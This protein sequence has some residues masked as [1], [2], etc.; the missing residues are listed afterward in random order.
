MRRFWLAA[1]MLGTSEV[2]LGIGQA[3]PV[4]AGTG[5]I[6]GILVSADRGEPVRKATVRLAAS[7]PRLNRSVTT[8]SDGR[9]RFEQLPAAEYTLTAVKGGFVDATYGAR[10]FGP[11]SSGA[12]IVGTPVTLSAG[13]KIEDIRFPIPRGGVI[14]GTV[15]DEFGDPAFNVVVRALRLAVVNG[16]RTVQPAGL[17]GTTDD[18]G[19]FRIAGLP[20][21]EYLVTA[22]PRDT[23]A[24][25]SSTNEAL[26]M[27]QA[28]VLAAARAS[29]D[30]ARVAEMERNFA[31]WSASVP[32]TT[33]G[34]VPVYYPGVVQPSAAHR[35]PLA[36][37]Q[38][39]GGID[40][41]LQVVETATVVATV[42]SAETPKGPV[43][44]TLLDPAMP[45][46]GVGALF[47]TVGKDRRVT[48]HG[49]VPG[50][51][52]LSSFA[53]LA[54]SVSGSGG[55]VTGSRE[56]TVVAG[57]SE[58]SLSLERGVSV[59]GRLMV[60]DLKGQVG[61]SKVMIS[62]S[63]IVRSGNWEMAAYRIGANPAGLF[64]FPNV[65]PATYRVSL[66]GL[67]QGWSLASAQL[68]GRDAADY[69]LTVEA[70]KPLEGLE[71]RLTDRTSEVSGALTTAAGAVPAGYTVI[72]FPAD[73]SLWLP[74]SR[75]IV[76]AQAGAD[77]RYTLRGL[78]A[79]EYRVLA[80]QD[81]EP[82][83]WFDREWLTQHASLAAS[84]KLGN[85]ERGTQDFRVR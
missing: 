68:G 84:V 4:P 57:S 1:V 82:G 26:K 18:R 22:T 58:H 29:G 55:S 16:E 53:E 56:I 27:R 47:R 11:A 37:S 20:P 62:L 48:F 24:T 13:Q 42:T 77:G 31:D 63:P 7:S 12:P 85:G 30:A 49:V 8:D 66:A 75:R 52:V 34:Y 15:V 35:V 64:V 78:P 50:Q 39:A 67:P 6:A 40:M 28:E 21:G 43:N 19:I 45:V 69:H 17:P 83:A 54:P 2:L 61:V 14:T 70:G 46:A 76:A 59:A 60:D 9:F 72:A 5:G 74:Q 33:V 44:V 41:R 32:S 36:L 38:E 51:Y 71:I 79:G 23:I 3:P 65:D 73:S 10:R 80:V 25:T 81:P